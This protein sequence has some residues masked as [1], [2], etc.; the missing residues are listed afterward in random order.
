MSRPLWEAQRSV[1]SDRP[2][3][4]DAGDVGFEEL[5]RF[6]NLPQVRLQELRQNVARCLDREHTVG[7][8]RVLAAYPPRN[9]MMEVA[10]YLVIAEGEPRHLVLEDTEVITLPS[11][12]R[13][14]RWRVP[15]I[16]FCRG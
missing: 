6:G 1:T 2:V 7:L 15:R 5:R 14:R 10:G 11:A 16:L 4:L 9:G 13:Q 3:E 8:S 12:S